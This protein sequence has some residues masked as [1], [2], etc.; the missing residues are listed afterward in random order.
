LADRK[1][2]KKGYANL[3]KSD[4]INQMITLILITSTLITL[5]ILITLTMITLTM[6]SIVVG[7]GICQ[8]SAK[9]RKGFNDEKQKQKQ[10]NHNC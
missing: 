6:I 4:Y 10:S 8:L 9:Q 2:G 1:Y 5:V 7:P 3:C